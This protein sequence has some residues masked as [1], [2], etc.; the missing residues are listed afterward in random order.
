MPEP[1]TIAGRNLVSRLLREC[2]LCPRLA[3]AL[4]LKIRRINLCRTPRPGPDS[5]GTRSQVMD[6]YTRGLS[7]FHTAHLLSP[8][9]SLKGILWPIHRLLGTQKMMIPRSLTLLLKSANIMYYGLGMGHP[10]KMPGISIPNYFATC[11]L[12]VIS[13]GSI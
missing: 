3:G 7:F 1:H 13:D 11:F 12:A 8:Q 6:S 9:L 10:S 2:P 5:S 4:K